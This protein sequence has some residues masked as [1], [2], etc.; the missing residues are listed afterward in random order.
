MR[1][2][3]LA[4][5]HL[6]SPALHLRVHSELILQVVAEMGTAATNSMRSVPAALRYLAVVVIQDALEGAPEMPDNLVHAYL[7]EHPVFQYALFPIPP[8]RSPG[9]DPMYI[10]IAAKLSLAAMCQ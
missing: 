8:T 3:A 10:V 5:E 2:L 6:Q 1:H 4:P 7:L 9:C